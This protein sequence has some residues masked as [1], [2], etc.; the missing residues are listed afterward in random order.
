ML[1]VCVRHRVQ[2]GETRVRQGRTS[3]Y[4]RHNKTRTTEAVNQTRKACIWDRLWCNIW[5]MQCSDLYALYSMWVSE[6][7]K[8]WTW[9]K[10]WM[11]INSLCPQI[12]N[13]GDKQANAQLTIQA[14]T[15]TYNCLHRGDCNR[16]TVSV[17]VP[18]HKSERT[19]YFFLLCG[20]KTSFTSLFNLW[21]WFHAAHQE[22][23]RLRY[24]HYAKSISEQPVIRVMAVLEAPDENKPIM[25][26]TNIPLETPQLL[27]Q[28][29][30]HTQ[31]H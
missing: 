9:R 14:M 29:R 1:C 6:R 18:P 23:L 28:V 5:G 24:E 13:Q 8:W 2:G 16:K 4:R 20:C 30:V 22:V 11:V 25:A 31:R 17:T 21:V 12:E 19:I 3:D 15:V 10:G 26:V 27:V 7:M